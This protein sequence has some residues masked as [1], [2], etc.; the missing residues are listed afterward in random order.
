M[1]GGKCPDGSVC[2]ENLDDRRGIYAQPTC[3]FID[4]YVPTP[5][6]HSVD[7]KLSSFGKCE[8]EILKIRV[9]EALAGVHDHSHLGRGDTCQHDIEKTIKQAIL[10]QLDIQNPYSILSMI[11]VGKA[12]GGFCDPTRLL[13]CSKDD[14]CKCLENTKPRITEDGFTSDYCYL[15][16]GSCKSDLKKL[17]PTSAIQK[18]MMKKHYGS[19][20]EIEESC[21]NGNICMFV[22][23]SKKMCTSVNTGK[24]GHEG[25]PRM[26]RNK[27]DKDKDTS[28]ASEIL[29]KLSLYP[30]IIL[31]II[32]LPLFT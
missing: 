13:E 15:T 6:C 14:K 3:Q 30:K 26:E 7:E 12:K 2:Y 4:S 28:G 22:E 31:V 25:D 20:P 32:S 24:T 27:V 11:N 10:M 8:K 16:K 5:S 17:L 1:E 18:E 29:G 23:T 21:K 9:M 19:L